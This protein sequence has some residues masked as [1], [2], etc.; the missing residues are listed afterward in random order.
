MHKK[1]YEEADA[2]GLG[3]KG[4]EAKVA[5]GMLSTASM[6]KPLKSIGEDEYVR[7]VVGDEVMKEL[8]VDKENGVLLEVHQA[9]RLDGKE[10]L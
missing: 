5:A 10:G 1:V 7:R 4:T 3:R 9:A 6:I 8:K 2:R